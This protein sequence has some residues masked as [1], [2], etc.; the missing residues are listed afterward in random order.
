MELSFRFDPSGCSKSG[1]R[2]SSLAAGS[3]KAD[4]SDFELAVDDLHRTLAAPDTLQEAGAL[5][6]LLTLCS[7]AGGT[8]FH[9][10]YHRRRPEVQCISSPVEAALHVWSEPPRSTRH[11]GTLG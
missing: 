7:V 2:A 11:V 3:F 1:Q 4:R 5:K 9:Q 6:E 8:T 10:D